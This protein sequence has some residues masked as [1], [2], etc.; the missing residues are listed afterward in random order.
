MFRH[1]VGLVFLAALTLL[2][3]GC[4]QGLHNGIYT[5][6]ETGEVHE[7]VVYVDPDGWSI[8]V[9]GTVEESHT[10][11][12]EYYDHMRAGD[13]G[14]PIP[15]WLNQIWNDDV[16][17]GKHKVNIEVE[18]KGRYNFLSFVL[19]ISPNVALRW[20]ESSAINLTVA[21]SDQIVSY[22]SSNV[23]F[24]KGTQKMVFCPTHSPVT[25]VN[26]GS[27]DV[28]QWNEGAGGILAIVEFPFGGNVPGAIVSCSVDNVR[29]VTTSVSSSAR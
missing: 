18:K 26:D 7:G 16:A 11:Y 10:R 3:M 19:K 8:D 4:S 1:K 20:T 25:L 21:D 29:V 23:Y 2:V 27:W 13:D 9:V 28:G 14:T 22:S 6:P 12:W 17:N 5:D 24:T 15:G